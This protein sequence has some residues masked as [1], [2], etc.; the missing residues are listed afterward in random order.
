MSYQV[1]SRSLERYSGGDR[2]SVEQHG[3]HD[4]VSAG[5]GGGRSV[6]TSS[7]AVNGWTSDDDITDSAWRR[8]LSSSTNRGKFIPFCSTS[9]TSA[10]EVMFLSWFICLLVGLSVSKKLCMN[11]RDIF[12]K[13]RRLKRKN[14]FYLRAITVRGIYYL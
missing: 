1:R 13:G 9:V 3:D 10:N 8:T 14:Q 12:W 2:L 11:L 5:P 7:S 4:F 6:K